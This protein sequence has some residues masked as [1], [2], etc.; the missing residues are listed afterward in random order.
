[1]TADVRDYWA[2]GDGVADDTAALQAAL[3]ACP[4]GGAVLLPPG[5]VYRVSSVRLTGRPVNVLAHGAAVLSTMPGAFAFVQSARGRLGWRGGRFVGPGNGYALSVPPS[6]HQSYDFA[7][8]GVSFELGATAT[9]L[10]LAGGREGTVTNCFFDSCT[11]IHLSETVNT[12]IMGCQFRNCTNAVWA[13]G[14]SGTAYNAGLMLTGCTALGCGYGVR[15]E[16]WDWASLVNCVIDYCDRPVELV[17]VDKAAIQASYLSNREFGGVVAP[18]VRVVTDPAR[19]G[20]LSQHVRIQ[21]CQIVNHVNALGPQSIGVSL[22]GGARYCSVTGNS[23]HFWQQYGV[24]V[25]GPAAH[26]KILANDL[27]QVG[28]LPGSAAVS[29]DELGGRSWLIADNHW[30][31]PPAGVGGARLRD[32]AG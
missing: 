32:N 4:P 5:G 28:R 25:V 11:G 7:F 30:S 3:D 15:A 12:H 16:G 13:D 17:N 24:R 26:L 9:A 18:V 8:D 23:I 14:S 21:G 1:M 20:T 31:S 6:Q 2:R 29:G 10:S 27:N 22:E 19:K